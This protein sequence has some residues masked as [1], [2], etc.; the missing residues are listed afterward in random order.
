MSTENIRNIAIIAHVDHGKTTLVDALLRQT[1]TFAAHEKVTD[2]AMDSNDL[3]RERG[4][5]I[6]AKTTGVTYKGHRVNIVD[7]PGHADFGGEVE[8]ILGMVDGAVLL[9][10]AAEGPMPQTKFVL[11]KALQLGLRPI[12][13][14]NKVD[15]SDARPDEVINETFDLFDSLGAT[16][17]Q[18]D[19]P[20]MYA[21]GRDGWVGPDYKNP[22]TST[23]PLLD[24]VLKHVP[25]PSGDENAPF[26]LLATI[27][28]RNDFLGR[29]VTGRVMS[30]TIKKN[31]SI[32]AMTRTGED[33]EK[34]KVTAL[35][36]FQ[37]LKKVPAEEAKA[38]DIVA[39]AGLSQAYVSHT[40]C[41][42]G[43]T[44]PLP[45]VD[46]DPPT[47]M[48]TFSVNDS[49]L[50]GREGKK[51]T[52]REIGARLFAEAETNV[53]LRVEQGSSAE[54]FKVMGRGE[55]HLGVL[56]ETMRR[57][58]F[59]LSISRPEIIFREENGVKLEPYEEIII[60]VD[61]EFSGV[62]MEKMGYRRAEL[63][64]MV[65]DHHSKTRLIFVGPS[66]G[67]IGYRSE[68]LTD[69]RGTGILTRQ[70]KEYG[71][72]KSAPPGRRNGVLVSMAAGTTT[73][74]ILNELEARGVLFVGAAIEAYDGMIIG[75]N[76]R[77]G[78]LEVNP[79]HAKKLTNVRAAGKDDAVKLTPPRQITLEYA[80]TYIEDDELVEVTP[81]NI[82]LRKRGLDANARKRMKRA[83]DAA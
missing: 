72:V 12:L 18:M 35:F 59:E 28:E 20:I 47:M 42:P 33:V 11:G 2:R 44:T 74:Y 40:I 53:G 76:S 7:T 22:T 64:N 52:S 17:E 25:A 36:T 27:I 9:V 57:E 61:Q 81:S 48:M 60:D 71:P 10:D 43:I 24:L 50:C 68:F 5:T 79:T 75:E 67:M 32:K 3:E 69:T 38:G 34:G 63:I 26:S 30:G 13:V 82:R 41:E 8:R 21:V 58:G 54:S 78:D 45:A 4:I 83:G 29:V 15:R 37:G 62:V 6:L 80:L 14:V 51:L 19:F 31:M 66:R 23:E 49:P 16:D 55:L 70:F 73:A 77:E 56:I 39:L 1:G 46:I 65:S